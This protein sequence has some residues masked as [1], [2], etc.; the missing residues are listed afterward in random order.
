MMS[1]HPDQPGINADK[2]PTGNDRDPGSPRAERVVD[3]LVAA[4]NSDLPSASDADRVLQWLRS[5]GTNLSDESPEGDS[6]ESVTA[7]DE[8]AAGRAGD[9]VILRLTQ[10]RLLGFDDADQPAGSTAARPHI[11]AHHRS[12]LGIAAE[13]EIEVSVSAAAALLICIIDPQTRRFMSLARWSIEAATDGGGPN[14]AA[15]RDD[16]GGTPEVATAAAGSWM[17]GLSTRRARLEPRE[18]HLRQWSSAAPPPATVIYLVGVAIS[19]AA[20]SDSRLSGSEEAAAMAGAADALGDRL[21]QQLREIQSDWGS[22]APTP[23]DDEDA[24]SDDLERLESAI[25]KSCVVAARDPAAACIIEAAPISKLASGMALLIDASRG[26]LGLTWTPH[27]ATSTPAARVSAQPLASRRSIETRRISSGLFMRVAAAVALIITLAGVY[28]RYIAD[29]GTA[30]GLATD[31]SGGV[32]GELRS[33]PRF[34][35]LAF[36]PGPTLRQPGAPLDPTA[37]SD[38]IVESEVAAWV[39]LVLVDRIGRTWIVPLADE[40]G[41][42]PPGVSADELE[43]VAEAVRAGARLIGKGEQVMLRIPAAVDPADSASWTVA[44][45]VIARPFGHPTG[46]TADAIAAWVP[47][48][49]LSAG[50]SG[51][52]IE[53][54]TL[55]PALDAIVDRLRGHDCIAEWR[56]V[57][58]SMPPD[59]GG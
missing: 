30:D 46:L 29:D 15:S 52:A 49:L 23:T 19:E 40:P 37:R 18:L 50:G 9:L 27:D 20:L 53:R 6:S 2:V 28:L 8:V 24:R 59:R 41:H 32:V 35:N 5:G 58:H 54:E 39:R 36:V 25:I 13:G 47:E 56:S 12:S 55:V 44:A 17:R 4:D 10:L 26:D 7:H 42:V 34:A 16:G 43:Q 51:E 48:E 31:G 22:A 21:E 1:E 33:P 38:M 14:A 3:D 11:P 57:P 45:M